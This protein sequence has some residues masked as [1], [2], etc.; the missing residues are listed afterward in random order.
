MFWNLLLEK[1]EGQTMKEYISWQRTKGDTVNGY[2]IQVN[3][4]FTSF[5]PNEI[6]KMEKWCN[7][8]IKAGV[9]I[10]GVRAYDID[11]YKEKHNESK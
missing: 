4:L 10:D 11:E 6:A 9:I 1:K 2:G 8:F 3:Y 5:D 7:E